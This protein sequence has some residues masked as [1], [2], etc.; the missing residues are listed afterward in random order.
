MRQHA[1]GG[2][3]AK[4]STDVSDVIKYM[5]SLLSNANPSDSTLLIA[6]LHTSFRDFLTDPKRSGKFYV[7]L[8]D[9][10]CQLAY[11]TLRT[12]QK[13]LRFN[14]CELETSYSLN[15]EVPD[16]KERIDKY[17]PPALSYSCRFW[18]DH[19]AQVPRFD[20]N[21]FEDLQL[22]MGE[23]FL[24]W[25]EVLSVRGEIPVATMALVSL[26]RWLGQMRDD[27]SIPSTA[28]FLLQL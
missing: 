14:I 15:S 17:I 26:R 3:H 24:F 1:G 6:P 25:L 22:F 19:L 8:D 11:A 4:N 21:V 27:V 2:G 16:L 7:D 5:G 9:T 20:T 28:T 12:M 10:R 18:A 13:T 23:N